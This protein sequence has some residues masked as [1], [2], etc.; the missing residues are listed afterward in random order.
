MQKETKFL[1]A[2]NWYLSKPGIRNDQHV[3]K[4][5]RGRIQHKGWGDR[6]DKN[7]LIK[8]RQRG[9]AVLQ[10]VGPETPS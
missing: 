8:L 3:Y 7:S 6:A 10:Q 9:Q 4:Y 5:Y 1:F 2:G